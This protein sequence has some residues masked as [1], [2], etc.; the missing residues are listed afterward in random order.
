MSAEKDMSLLDGTRH[1]D[2]ADLDHRG[3]FVDYVLEHADDWHREHLG[4]L[5]AL[6]EDW[7]TEH[8]Q[9]VLWV[10]YIELY[11]TTAPNLY[12]CC[13]AISGFGGKLGIRIRPS[14]LTGTHPHMRR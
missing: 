9:G 13:S 6:W 7:N 11:E 3:A 2:N 14:L 10:P 5:F 1:L 4:R 12:G 8:Y